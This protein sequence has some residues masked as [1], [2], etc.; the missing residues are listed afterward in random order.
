MI[1]NSFGKEITKS[2][3]WLCFFKQFLRSRYQKSLAFFLFNKS[4][5]Y[6]F[7]QNSLI[8]YIFFGT[9]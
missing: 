2:P 9:F 4:F 8:H 5:L 6:I 7:I 3:S 1:H